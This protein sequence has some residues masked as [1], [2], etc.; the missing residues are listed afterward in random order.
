MEAQSAR[1]KREAGVAGLVVLF[2]KGPVVQ[3]TSRPDGTMR[4]RRFQEKDLAQILDGWR[5]RG[6][7]P[8]PWST[9]RIR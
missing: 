1:I 6:Y 2:E 8:M 4:A 7:T 9:V 5:R 3:V